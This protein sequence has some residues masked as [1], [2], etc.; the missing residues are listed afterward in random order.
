[1][2]FQRKKVATALACMMGVGGAMV[3]SGAFGQAKNPDVP[4][5][6]RPEANPDIRV[7]VTGSNI[8][9]VEGEGALPVTVITRDQID[10][11]GATTPMELLQQISANNSLGAV[12]IANSVGA[13]TLAQQGAS[14]R[15]LGPA[16]TL[17]L[18]NGHR[19]ENFAGAIQGVE[20]GANLSAIPF[21]A[22]E[23]VE[24]LKDGASAIY[25]SDAIGGVI[26]FI[27]RS[28]YTGGE[29]TGF[30]GT[31]TKGGGA[32]GR[33][34]QWK[35]NGSFG[36]GDLAKDRYNVFGTVSYA[37]QKP[38]DQA[39]RRFSNTDSIPSIG[40][41][42]G[43]SNTFPGNVRTGGIGVVSNGQIAAP[44]NCAPARYLNVP[45]IGINGCVADLASVPGVEMIPDD[46][47]WNAFAQGKFQINNDWQ[48]Y[49]MGLYSHDETRLV[50]QPGPISSVFSY[51]PDSTPGTILLQPTSPFYP[52]AVAAEHGVDGKP[53]N[54]RWRAYDAG[55]RDTTDTA[56]TGEAIVG[57][58]G[59]W[60]DWDVDASGFYADGKT[61]ERTNGG[62][63]DYRLIL[64]L[65]NS[66]TVNLF[67]PNTPDI[68]SQI[69]A[70]N[71]IGDTLS[72]ESKSYGFQGK[73][74]G[75]IWKLPAGPLN[76]AL[77]AETRK[78]TLEQNPA[79]AIQGGYITGYGGQ[80]KPV[81]GSRTQWA[82]FGELNIP[83]VKTLEANAQVR[84][85]HYSDFGGTTNP[86]ISLRW[87]PT[88]SMLFRGSWGTGFLA[89]ALFELHSVN[90][91]GVSATGLSD[92]I[93][94]PV[95]GDTGIDCVT[96]FSVLF[97]GNPVLKPEESEQ[98]TL[99]FVLEPFVGASFSVDYFKINLKNAIVDGISPETV[100]GD[101]G[102]FGGLVTRGP[103][104]PNFPNLPGP[105]T[106]IAQT[107]VNVGSEHIQGL[108][109]EGHYR[110]PMQSWGR[111]SFNLSGTYYLRYDSQNTDGTWSGNVGTILNSV[112]TGVIPRWKHYASLSWD[113]GPWGA[114][115]AQT[116][117][118]SYTDAG[119]DFDGNLRTVGSLSI[120]DLQ[121]TYSGFKNTTLTLGVKNL[122]DR[123][124]PATNQV[125]NFLAGFDS[126]YYDPRARF[127]YG[128]V[129]YRFK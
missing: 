84:Y 25:G 9:R 121:G 52:H 87:Q 109:I 101:I 60:R 57:I 31:P 123:D 128:S 32:S 77:G 117:Q 96:Q 66:G 76:L 65:L 24:V 27:T 90:T 23:R 58:K 36:F 107:Y 5:A 13:T 55:F 100:L 120:W 99:G 26:N 74:S 14:L 34:D 16:R 93:R 2:S 59:T 86:K 47:Q 3:M 38:M 12:N 49:A 56:E 42:A 103:V 89:P 44:N 78:E 29:V 83:I 122:F 68:V 95:T 91:T 1:M 10:R 48:A 61:R 116:Y 43:S 17:V 51:G 75:E 92:P 79:E 111:L 33:G 63:Q 127:I 115:L 35:A 82:T 22:I 28:D 30:Y 40:Y 81:S 64:P 71:F 69:R 18:I 125:G 126:S 98:A 94:C 112:N 85:D 108:D 129:T 88:R 7:E 105:I 106:S 104:D 124:P 73:T 53:L 21:D 11:S 41:Y 118:T 45:A 6:T 54:V 8:R 46:K 80:N 20:Q 39:S 119:T 4:S 67:G 15:G 37:E 50:I 62:F 72:G 19:L 110:T 70:T 97:G 102:Q 114:T 113:Q